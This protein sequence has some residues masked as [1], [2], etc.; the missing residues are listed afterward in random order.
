MRDDTSRIWKILD[1]LSQLANV[2]LIPNHKDTTANESV[3][4][5]AYRKGWGIRHFINLLFFWQENHCEAA[6]FNDLARARLLVES[7]TDGLPS[8]PNQ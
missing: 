2:T 7:A 8:Q 1:A 3:S 4:G 6:Y 5:R